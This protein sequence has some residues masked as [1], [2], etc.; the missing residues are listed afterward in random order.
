L[1]IQDHRNEKGRRRSPPP[2]KLY[3]H[4]MKQISQ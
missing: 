4:S 1:N 2:A 3:R